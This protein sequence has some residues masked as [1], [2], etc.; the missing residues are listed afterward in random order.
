M[1]QQGV[2]ADSKLV[3]DLDFSLPDRAW[4]ANEFAASVL[5]VQHALGVTGWSEGSNDCDDF[6]RLA[7]ALAQVLHHRTR[8][9]RKTGLA[10]GEFWYWKYDLSQHAIVFVIVREGDERVLLFWEPQT[11]QF[12]KLTNEEKSQCILYRC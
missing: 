8:T 7:A 9:G 10:I 6:A 5:S 4:V 3:A 12:V 11:R 2:R 1:Y